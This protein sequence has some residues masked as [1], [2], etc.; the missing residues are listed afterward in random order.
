MINIHS[1]QK[2]AAMLIF[3]F[4]FLMASLGIVTAISFGVFKDQAALR[5]LVN[6]KQSY[7]S[8]DSAIEDMAYRYIS[9]KTPGTTEVIT[10]GGVTATSTVVYSNTELAYTV[11]SD[12]NDN[13]AYRSASMKLYVGSGASFNF[14]VQAGN[15]GFELTNGSSV[16]GNVFS[17]GYIKKTGGGT[18]TIYGDVISAGASGLIENVNAT[19]SAWAH[20][21]KNSNITKNVYTYTLNGGVTTGG[22]EYY[23]KINGAIVNGTPEVSGV[24]VGDEATTTMPISDADIDAMKQNII[25]T[26]T[27]ITATSSQCSTGTYEISSS[28]SI[29]NVRIGCNFQLKKQGAGTTLTVTGPI[30]VEGNTTF[31]SGP[32]VVIA[33]SVGNRTVPIIADKVSNRA[34]SSKIIVENGT[35]FA[36][37]G[38]SMSFILLISQNRDAENGGTY[39]A[40]AMSLAQSSSG[41]LLTYASHGRITLANSIALNEITGYKIVL[42]NSASI[43]YKSGL[44]NLLFTSGPGGGF[45][46]GSWKESQ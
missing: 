25:D 46:I 44:A 1:Q 17:N 2:G 7:L 26:G 27:R 45:T 40:D 22:A 39:N 33:N 38:G 37:T 43:V 8:A 41:D 14:G 13:R 9:G 31:K 21:V 5:L 23:N 35:T 24:I 11:Q 6:S 30:W 29:G 28:V 3:V 36:G 10:L 12:A 34:T 20:V 42:G 19:G 32:R 16:R 4:F 18:A 15:G